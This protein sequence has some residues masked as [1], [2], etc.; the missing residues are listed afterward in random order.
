MKLIIDAETWLYMFAASCIYSGEWKDHTNPDD[1][2]TNTWMHFF[3]LSEAQELF[4]AAVAS[5]QIMCPEHEPV[6]AFGSR[7]NF[8]YSI[9][10]DYKSSRRKTIKPAGYAE[11]L[12]PWAQETWQ[13]VQL[14][15]VEADDVCGIISEPDD[16]IASRDKDLMTLPG[17]HIKGDEV[18]HVSEQTADHAFYM[19][20]LTGD[21]TDGYP[22]IKGV[23]PKKAQ[24]I[25]DTCK[26][27]SQWWQAVEMAYSAAG[28]DLDY[29]ITQARCARILRAGEYDHEN[30]RPR[31]WEPVP[32]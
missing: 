32:F 5:M 23:G 15:G 22:G 24:A 27:P 21:V 25:L 2:G 1:P 3:R 8:R 13:S 30:K 10:K 28:H 26:H 19:Q 17:W 20:C 7:T 31:L 12:I 18:L 14:D 29:A 9:Y 16:V 11:A 4:R 6:L